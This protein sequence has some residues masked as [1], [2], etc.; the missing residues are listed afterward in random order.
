[1][2]FIGWFSYVLLQLLV[3]VAVNR[4]KRRGIIAARAGQQYALWG[5]EAITNWSH[6][7]SGQAIDGGSFAQPIYQHG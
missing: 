4:E 1:V 2:R 6:A 7:G 3:G 5:N